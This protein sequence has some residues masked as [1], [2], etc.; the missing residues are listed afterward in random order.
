MI[1]LETLAVAFSMYSGI[2]MPQFEWNQKNMR[3][4]MAAFPLIGLVI[5]LAEYLAL[6]ACE[7]LGLAGLLR[8]A[9]LCILPILITGG[10]HLDG[11]SDTEDALASHK[12]PEEKQQIL[13]DPHVGSFALIRIFI[14]LLLSFALW[15]TLPA[16]HALEILF[17]FCISRCL[18]GLSVCS[19]PLAKSSGL[20]YTFAEAADKKRT[21]R[22]LLLFLLFSIAGELFFGG[23]EGAAALLAAILVFACYYRTAKKEFGGLSGDLAGWFLQKCELWMLI[24]IY[25]VEILEK[26][27]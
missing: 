5:G 7:W 2:P 11:Y 22:I 6:L 3:Y 10:I 24:G 13:K 27:I 19:F 21:R 12:S 26:K 9:I 1:V 16:Y 17:L 23:A 25:L 14:Y 8:G 4:A 15:T 18:S 20:V